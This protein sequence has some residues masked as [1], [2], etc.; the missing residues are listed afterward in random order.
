[1]AAPASIRLRNEKAH[2][3]INRRGT[4]FSQP[5]DKS[6]TSRVDPIL[7]GFFLFVVVGSCEL[8]PECTVLIDL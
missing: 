6:L 2:A 4:G 8:P 3:N 1:M 7:L 5:E